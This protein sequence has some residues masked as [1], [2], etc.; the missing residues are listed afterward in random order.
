MKEQRQLPMGLSIGVIIIFITMTLGVCLLTVFLYNLPLIFPPPGANSQVAGLST[1]FP[2]DTP[3]FDT[4]T[5]LPFGFETLTTP[6]VEATPSIP[7][8]I[9]PTTL[10]PPP[11]TP[12]PTL[13]VATATALATPDAAP[14]SGR[15]VFVAEQ[16]GA[17]IF[18]MNH[19]GSGQRL[20]VPHKGNS[21][22]FAPA[23]SPDGR[24][25]A[26]AST[27]DKGDGDEIFVVNLDGTR[28]TQ[29]TNTRKVRN[30]SPS[31]FPD[32]KRL[33]F[34]SDRSG[35]WKAYTMDADGS[36]IAQ[37]LENNQDILEVAVSPDGNKIAH[38]CG[39]EICLANA[40]KS[41]RRVLLKNGLLK[42]HLAWS[43]DSNLLAFTQHEAN[44][45]MLSVYQVDLAGR[46]RQLVSNGGMASWS[47]DGN[48]I[49]FSSNMEGVSNLYSYD[50]RTGQVYRLTTGAAIYAS[51]W[52]P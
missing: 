26:F 28:L 16:N 15:I 46:S 41:D 1:I 5:L 18:V 11:D 51:I 8:T 3:A 7:P 35:R 40:D 29:L 2:T 47:P 21:H 34:A 30:V 49:V 33:A 24:R 45:N 12:A 25:L 23:V 6:T 43:P 44:S 20:L 37:Y 42:D 4:P 19:D 36:H 48:R 14:S 13:P 52:M 39:K 17:S 27:R 38:T 50:L 22:D 10:P 31:W 9:T 32:G